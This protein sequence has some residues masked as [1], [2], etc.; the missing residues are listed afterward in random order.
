MQDELRAMFTLAQRKGYCLNIR[1]VDNEPVFALGP[2][3]RTWN[4]FL[5]ELGDDPTTTLASW[6]GVRRYLDRQ[7][8]KERPELSE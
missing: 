2:P 4:D 6:D 3:K 1:F 5:P 7:G 8:D